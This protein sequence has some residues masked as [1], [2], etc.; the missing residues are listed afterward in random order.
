MCF[1]VCDNCGLWDNVL[2]LPFID[3][4]TIIS[5]EVIKILVL[6][7]SVIKTFKTLSLTVPSISTR[8]LNH[9]LE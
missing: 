1:M 4:F 3:Q 8:M 2:Y 6:P 7:S 9:I 5:Y